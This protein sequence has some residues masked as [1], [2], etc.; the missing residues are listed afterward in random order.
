[1]IGTGFISDDEASDSDSDSSDSGG[2]AFR[3]RRVVHSPTDYK[4][5]DDSA[6]DF[7]DITELADEAPVEVKDPKDDYDDI[8]AAIPAA[9][10][11]VDGASKSE[12]NGH[13]DKNGDHDDKELMPPPPQNAAPSVKLDEPDA[14]SSASTSDS[15][16]KYCSITKDFNQNFRISHCFRKRQKA[17]Y[18]TECYSQHPLKI[19]RC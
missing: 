1:M 6:E 3:R 15:K 4:N 10:V 18:T 14:A 11:S 16:S 7:F 9:K 17:G 2:R 5:K 12:D 8:E 13:S 19:C